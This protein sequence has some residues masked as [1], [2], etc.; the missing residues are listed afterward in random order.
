LYCGVY[1]RALRVELASWHPAGAL[2]L[3]Y[4]RSFWKCEHTVNLCVFHG[5]QDKELWF[6]YTILTF[7]RIARRRR[8]PSSCLS[9]CLS[10]YRRGFHWTDFREILCWEIA[11]KSSDELQI[12]AESYRNFGH[13]TYLKT[14]ELLL[15]PATQK[16]FCV[17]INMSVF[18]TVKCSSTHRRCIFVFPM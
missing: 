18:L 5:S 16:H 3:M 10:V 9:V 7:P 12:R 4:R 6:C 8:L 14:Q 15:F 1:L 2:V 17:T 11:W 13:F